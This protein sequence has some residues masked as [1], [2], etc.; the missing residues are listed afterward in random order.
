MYVSYTLSYM[1]DIQYKGKNAL[2]CISHILG[3]FP[4]YKIQNWF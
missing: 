2:Y 4:E 1:Y 3:M